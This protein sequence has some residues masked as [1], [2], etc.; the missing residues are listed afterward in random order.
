MEGCTDDFSEAECV[1]LAQE[2]MEDHRQGTQGICQIVGMDEEFV[3]TATGS[4]SV[5]RW[6][7]V[8]KKSDREGISQPA[9]RHSASDR[10]TPLLSP[11]SGAANLNTPPALTLSPS[12][13]G[14][15]T[16]AN[17]P[18]YK[19]ASMDGIT[20]PAAE[21]LQ[22]L[23]RTDSR[24]S[25]TVAFAPEPSTASARIDSPRRVGSFIQNP[26]GTTTGLA[27]TILPP[28][29]LG[30]GR[31]ASLNQRLTTL[32]GASVAGSVMSVDSCADG[33][34]LL[35]GL[36]YTSFICLGI[37]ETPYMPNG[38]EGNSG[39]AGS[40]TS[41]P[42]PPQNGFAAMSRSS[43]QHHRAPSTS[44]HAAFGGD[45]VD[46][47]RREYLN[48]E[49]A[50]EATPVRDVPDEVIRGRHGLIRAAILSDRQHV[51]TVDTSGEMAVWNIIKGT[52][53]GRFHHDDVADIVGH[54][55]RD[56]KDGPL[57]L[58]GGQIN[59]REA[60]ELVRERVEGESMTVTWCSVDTRIGSLTVHLEESRCFDADV[61]AD[62][63][64]FGP[65]EFK[66]DHRSKWRT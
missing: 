31:P 33:P 17:A 50:E 48:R 52:C 47:A 37:P 35:N 28:Q 32:S 45:P 26:D 8:G 12:R 7:D 23:L 34:P 63:A 42:F 16:E 27:G 39:Y 41:V 25:R 4:A 51:L 61:Y 9:D 22:S 40:V 29:V 57:Y 58:A 11:A 3:W 20:F 56:H 30:L 43:S 1:L 62:E 5:K 19:R 60:L 53:V 55:T 13:N 64:G 21:F 36:P 59:P 46:M 65:D 44:S 18:R 49:V 54:D 2:E 24:D 10:G 66:E 15:G 38:P 6:K 14:I